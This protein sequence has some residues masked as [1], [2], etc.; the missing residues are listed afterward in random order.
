MQTIGWKLKCSIK[1]K[2]NASFSESGDGGF[3]EKKSIILVYFS[4]PAE[5]IKSV[6]SVMGA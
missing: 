3:D 2:N 6:F 1:T 5:V 4:T